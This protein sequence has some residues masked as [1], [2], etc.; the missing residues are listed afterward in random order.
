MVALLHLENS[1]DLEALALIS[2]GIY[3]P[4]QFP[5]MIIR[6]E[7]PKVTFLVFSSGKIVIAGSTSLEDLNNATKDVKNIIKQLLE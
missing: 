3:E 4:E 2:D 5:G 7:E 1:V 6:H